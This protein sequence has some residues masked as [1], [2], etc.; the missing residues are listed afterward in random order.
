MAPPPPPLAPFSPPPP[1]PPTAR[2]ETFLMPDGGVQ[3][4]V[5]PKNEIKQYPYVIACETVRPVLICGTQS[6]P[7]ATVFLVVVDNIPAALSYA[8]AT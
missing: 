7:T 4:P 1:P 8:S 5:P 6:P 2:K 3:V